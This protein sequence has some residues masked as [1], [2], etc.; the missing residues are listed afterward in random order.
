MHYIDESLITKYGGHDDQLSQQHP[1]MDRFRVRALHRLLD[2]QTLKTDDF[3]AACHV[4]RKKLKILVK[5]AR[6]H[7]ND[8]VIEEFEPL[9]QR[10]CDNAEA[11]TC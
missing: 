2:T 7:H 10:W 11:A 3:D 6:K 4:L 9:L 1:L 5:G 8:A